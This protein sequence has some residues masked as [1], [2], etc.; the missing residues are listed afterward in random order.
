MNKQESGRNKQKLVKI[1]Y[2]RK[3][4]RAEPSYLRQHP[5]KTRLTIT[6]THPPHSFLSS[7]QSSQTIFTNFSGLQQAKLAVSTPH[8]PSMEIKCLQKGTKIYIGNKESSLRIPD[9]PQVFPPVCSLGACQEGR[10]WQKKGI[11]NFCPWQGVT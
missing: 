3:T 5:S 11:T 8:F 9:Q 4:Q 1:S 6:L 7:Q 2:L 10:D